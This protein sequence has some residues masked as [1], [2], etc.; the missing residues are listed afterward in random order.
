[1]TL[2]VIAQNSQVVLYARKPGTKQDKYVDTNRY[3][4]YLACC[5]V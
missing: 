1:M 5:G 2:T 3:V 4:Y